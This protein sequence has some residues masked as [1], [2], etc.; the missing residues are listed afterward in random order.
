MHHYSLAMLDRD[1]PAWFG[2]INQVVTGLFTESLP[3]W[4]GAPAKLAKKQEVDAAKKVAAA[5]RQRYDQGS[6]TGFLETEL[7]LENSLQQEEYGQ[8]LCS[9]LDDPNNLDLIF[10]PEYPDRL[11]SGTSSTLLHGLQ[12]KGQWQH[13]HSMHMS[14]ARKR[15]RQAGVMA[16]VMAARETP[17]VFKELHGQVPVALICQFLE[18]GLS[19]RELLRKLSGIQGMAQP[20]VAR[21]V[22][23]GAAARIRGMSKVRQNRHIRR[24]LHDFTIL[25]RDLKLAY[26]THWI[27]NQLRILVLEQDVAL[28][29]SN[30]SLQ[31]FSQHNVGEEAR[32]RIRNHVIIKADVRGSTAI[33]E[34]LHDQNL[35]PASHFSLNFFQPINHLIKKFGA[36][37]VFVEG[38]AVILSILEYEDTPYQWLAVCHACGLA[39]K[40]LQVVD[41]QNAK[42]RKHGLPELELGLG[43]S[44]SDG[45]PAFLYDDD[46]EIMISH[47]INRADRLSSC[48]AILRSTSIGENK[49]RGV[50]VV[51]PVEQEVGQADGADQLL[52][53]NVNGIEMDMPAFFK[54]KTELAL[55]RIGHSMPGYSDHNMFYVGR[56]PDRTGKMQWLVMREAPVRLWVGNDASTEEEGGRRFF[57]VVTDSEVVALVKEKVSTKSENVADKAAKEKYVGDETEPPQYLH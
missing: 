5:L 4:T 2:R 3:P 36:N 35:N 6:L 51:V 25:R 50:E 37:K 53:Y 20:E 16:R 44:F 12:S 38:D 24:F 46:H 33:I 39:E 22:L 57:E 49:S 27:M 47:A 52:R 11:Y 17:R 15:L 7:L 21:G 43:I 29:R 55:R 48:S 28:S 8:G 19:R 41:A 42:N 45:S 32:N 23:D 30:S 56:Y 14:E 18:R 54:L 10:S 9:W 13:F 1:D 26:R 40:I 31:E 34:Q